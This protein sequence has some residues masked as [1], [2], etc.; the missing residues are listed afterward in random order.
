M[1]V[2]TPPHSRSLLCTYTQTSRQSHRQTYTDQIRASFSRY[3]IISLFHPFYTKPSNSIAGWLACDQN[4]PTLEYWKSAR[5]KRAFWRFE[6]FGWQ[7]LPSQRR[8][9]PIQLEYFVEIFFQP[10]LSS[11][12]TAVPSFLP[13]WD[14]L[15]G[16]VYQP[17]SWTPKKASAPVFYSSP[18]RAGKSK[19]DGRL[20]VGKCFQKKL[21]AHP[22]AQ[23]LGHRCQSFHF[24]QKDK[25]FTHKC[26]R[27][28]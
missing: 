1:I 12:I 6:Q 23:Y 25:H 4:L 8:V 9:I 15:S 13:Y 18:L 10:L 3:F 5:Q 2:I 28:L 24:S 16:N 7:P 26:Q 21:I 14:V 20:K 19:C 27:Q 11:R 17:R 22:C